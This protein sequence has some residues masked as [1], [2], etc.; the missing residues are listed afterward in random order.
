METPIADFY[1]LLHEARSLTGMPITQKIDQALTDGNV[2]DPDE[3]QTLYEQLYFEM[4][5]TDLAPTKIPNEPTKKIFF[6]AERAACLYRYGYMGWSKWP[7]H[8]AADA[9]LRRFQI[10]DDERPDIKRAICSR[11]AY[12]SNSVPRKK[13]KQKYI[14]SVQPA[15]PLSES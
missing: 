10:P 5:G 15:L 11:K 14:E 13:A 9:T 4:T 1:A 2:N 3:H 7:L 6:L 12:A 8:E